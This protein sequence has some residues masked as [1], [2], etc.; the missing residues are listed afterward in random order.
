VRPLYAA[1]QRGDYFG[2][3]ESADP[4]IEFVVRD[5]LSEATWTG[6]A[7]MARWAASSEPG[8]GTEAEEYRELGE[9][10]M[11]VLDTSARRAGRAVSCRLPRWPRARSG[12]FAGAYVR[13][14]AKWW[15]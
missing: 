6:V 9:K 2:S 15:E 14:R 11:L 7:G 12:H 8:R 1:W 10:S 5:G 13:P 3:A 4:E